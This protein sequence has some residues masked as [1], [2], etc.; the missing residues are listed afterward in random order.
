MVVPPA[1]R[2]KDAKQQPARRVTK[3]CIFQKER[4]LSQ[5]VG[6]EE[7]GCYRTGKGTGGAG[8]LGG[9]A[10]SYKASMDRWPGAGHMRSH[11]EAMAERWECS[12]LLFV[13]HLF[14]P[15]S[16]SQAHLTMGFWPSLAIGQP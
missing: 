14:P 3:G 7:L 12:G 11:R 9:R 10:G 2:P 5:G 6:K 13:V 16:V 15:F 1:L 8:P 4:A